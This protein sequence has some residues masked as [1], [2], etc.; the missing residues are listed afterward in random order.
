MMPI[1][2]M[3]Y[4]MAFLFEEAKLTI[5][6]RLVYEAVTPCNFADGYQFLEGT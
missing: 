1:S 3:K 2:E 6:L 4:E 5:K